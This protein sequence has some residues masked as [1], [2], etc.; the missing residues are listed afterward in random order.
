MIHTTDTASEER[1]GGAAEANRCGGA[2]E[3]ADPASVAAPTALSILGPPPVDDG[4]SG[5]DAAPAAAAAAAAEGEEGEEA[6]AAAGMSA[7]AVTAVVAD[8]DAGAAVDVFDPA[9]TAFGA[10]F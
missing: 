7:A 2:E 8:A 9:V 4:A 1:E 10:T 3:K 5:T 6:A